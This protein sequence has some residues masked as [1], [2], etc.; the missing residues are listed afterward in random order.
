MKMNLST[1]WKNRTEILEGI[2][3]NVFK[4]EAIEIIAEERK[5]KC[6]SCTFID[7]VGDRCMVPGTSPCCGSCG[8]SL[9]FKLRSMSTECPEGYWEAVLT[10]EEELMH[11]DLN[12]EEN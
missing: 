1:I 3:N 5:K 2:K 10:E 9:Q 4:K 6:E 8:C 11:E 7:T 12:E